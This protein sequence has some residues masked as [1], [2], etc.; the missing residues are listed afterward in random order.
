[1]TQPTHFPADF[2]WGVAT[3]AFQIE[4]ASAADGKGPSI[5]DT[6][7][8]QPGTIKDG[9]D[10]SVACD[11]YHRYREDVGLI[12]SLGVDAYRFSMAWSR[13]QPTGK[14]A[15]NEAASPSTSACWTPSPSAASSLT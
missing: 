12:A 8:S 2:T 6:F 11:H 4:G 9:S 3:S 13:V 1:M 5:W 10:G 7:C 14:G 15:W